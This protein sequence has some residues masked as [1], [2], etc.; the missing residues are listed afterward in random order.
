[1]RI[2]R[3][4][5]GQAILLFSL[6]MIVLLL[7]L[8]PPVLGIGEIFVARRDVG[9]QT[10][11]AAEQGAAALVQGSS[12][13]A[14][15]SAARAIAPRHSTVSLATGGSA[16]GATTPRE[17]VQ[18]SSSVPESI[19]GPFLLPIRVEVSECKAVVAQQQEAP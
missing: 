11:L 3:T 4:E 1:M 12:A 5:D 14:A 7:T 17:Y 16:C 15:I 9:R 19:T 10:M 13:A 2:K 8:I 6:V 18:V